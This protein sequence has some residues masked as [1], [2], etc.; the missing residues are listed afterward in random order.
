MS[1]PIPGPPRRWIVGNLPEVQRDMLGFF[2][3]CAR[4]Y[5]DVAYFRLGPRR[6]VLLSHPDHI[7]QVLVT[8]NRKF[9][10]NFALQLLRPLLGDGLLT[11]E[12][13]A[14]L[15]NRR[16]IQPAF[17]R[18]R[19]EEYGSTMV[20]LAQ[21]TV[22]GWR[23][24]QQVDMHA[25]MMKLTLAIAAKT[26]MGVDVGDVSSEVGNSLEV[27]MADFSS[28]FESVQPLPVW[29]PTPGN[30]KLKRAVRHLE[31]VIQRIVS[32]RRAS[33][34][35]G[36][37]LLSMLVHARD[38]DDGRGFTDRQLRDEVM[39]LLLAGHETTANALTWTWYLLAQHPQAEQRLLAE[40]EGVLAGRGP[41]VANLPRLVYTER[42]I[43]ESM[44]LYPP[45]Y[46]FGRR[47]VEP[48]TI[49]GYRLTV[50]TNALLPQCVVHRDPRWFEEPDRFQPDRWADD[51]IHRIPKYAYFPFGGGP[52]VCIGNT[53]AMIEA[54]LLLATMA[55]K[56]GLSLAAG[57]EVRPWASITLRPR[58]GIQ[59]VLR[60]RAP[61]PAA[62]RTV[63]VARR[64]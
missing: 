59:C 21:R 55:Q 24:G 62:E 58:N 22:T 26:L 43:L 9:A 57:H 49:G 38:E 2:Q 14:W 5:G 41:T 11:S 53:F 12:G 52:R 56:F 7:E 27:I 54:V 35:D 8:D 15:R 4:D 17:Q 23:D 25:E 42:V 36:S 3:R 46:S 31:Q 39:T 51:L 60:S 61:T 16:L 63:T 1:V 13:S 28:R 32:E 47:V 29:L 10:K 34:H 19:I 50:G 44:R 45:A 18:K 37:D 30:L 6:M 48:V 33:A 64:S 20:D 40:L